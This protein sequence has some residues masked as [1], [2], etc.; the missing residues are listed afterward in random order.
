[1]KRRSNVVLASQ[2]GQASQER[3]GLDDLRIESKRGALRPCHVGIVW[4]SCARERAGRR[5]EEID[6]T[7][8]HQ[9]ATSKPAKSKTVTISM[10]ERGQGR[11]KTVTRNIFTNT[12]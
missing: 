12:L 1:M 6:E 7:T 3:C 5:G 4:K 11:Q 9:Q 10:T 2:R 8:I